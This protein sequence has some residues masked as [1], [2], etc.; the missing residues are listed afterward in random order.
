MPFRHTQKEREKDDNLGEDERKKDAVGGGRASELNQA[1]KA[2][3]A[4]SFASHH[5]TDD[6]E[7]R[8]G[9]DNSNAESGRCAQRTTDRD[10]LRKRGMTF[11]KNYGTFYNLTAIQ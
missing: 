10:K 8:R 4:A 1:C 11:M 7:K 3:A 5:Q 2:T 9:R 6:E